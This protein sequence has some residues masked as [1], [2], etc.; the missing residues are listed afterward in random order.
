[1]SRLDLQSLLEDLI[2]SGN[3][4]FQPTVNIVMSYPCIVYERDTVKTEFADNT[5][6]LNKKRYRVTCIDRDPDSVLHE[7]VLT[8][9][10]ASYQRFFI[11]DGLNH[12][13]LNLYF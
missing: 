13:V 12:D 11:A 5:P 2:G 4:Y 7:L 3:V 9:P 10:L 6:Y 1:M 8:L